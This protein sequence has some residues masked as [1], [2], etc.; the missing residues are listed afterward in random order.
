MKLWADADSICAV[1]TLCWKH[2]GAPMHSKIGEKPEFLVEIKPTRMA[3][4]ASGGGC[5]SDDPTDRSISGIPSLAA[6]ALARSITRKAPASGVLKE[7]VFIMALPGTGEWR[8]Q[9]EWVNSLAAAN[10][11]VQSEAQTG[12]IPCETVKPWE[13][14]AYSQHAGNVGC[15]KPTGSREPP[16]RGDSCS[17]GRHNCMCTVPITFC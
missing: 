17:R 8:V 10:K 13:S 15:K 3:S 6:D 11:C 7:R 1:P 5:K 2:A 12:G 14:S 9:L 4:R 16:T